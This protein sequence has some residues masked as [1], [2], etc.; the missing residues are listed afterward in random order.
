MSTIQKIISH[1]RLFEILHESLSDDLKSSKLYELVSS[2]L[3][4]YASL[5]NL[6]AK[7]ISE[8]YSSYIS[9]FNKHCKKFAK[10]NEY[11]YQYEKVSTHVSR[12]DYD[13]ILILSALFTAHRFKIMQLIAEHL[14]TETKRLFVGAGPGLELYITEMSGQQN[15]VY[16]IALNDLLRSIFPN[17]QFF[18]EY[19]SDQYTNFFDSI[20]LIELLEHLKNPFDLL[21][22]CYNAIDFNG[23]LFLTTAT[24]IPQFDH[25]YNFP[26]NHDGFDDE[27][28]K[29]GW[30]ILYKEK[31]SHNY[32]LMSIK[33][34]NHFYIIQ[35]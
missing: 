34:S 33:P 32:L 18:Q 27:L 35:K 14:G 7:Y 10:T 19:F 30:R 6:D 5:N 8:V 3:D 28:T 4:N 22:N 2:Y 12:I 13:I 24:D 9:T 17:V 20:Y 1:N 26:E 29:M 25:L 23:K 15:F 16:D 11:P 31:I 21:Q